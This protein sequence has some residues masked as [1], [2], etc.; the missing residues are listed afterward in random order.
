MTVVLF[1]LIL[2]ALIVGHEA[3]HFVI[4]KWVGMKVLEF[5][6]GFPPKLWGTK[7]GDTEYTVNLVPF[8]GF[9]RIFGEDESEKFEE[10]AFARHH[11]GAQAAVLVAGP[12]ANVLLAF[13]AFWVAF[14]VGVPA[15]IQEGADAATLRDARVVIAD[16][17]PSAPAAIAG[18]VA[19]DVVVSIAHDSVV[20]P[21]TRPEDIANVLRD[22][23]GPLSV[24]YTH[25]NERKTA[26]VT[27][28]TGIIPDFPDRYGIGIA[29]VLV[30]TKVLDP[31]A[32]LVSGF[33]A[34]WQ[35]LGSI[36]VGLVTL[37]GSALTFSASLSD[38]SGPVGIASLVGDAA[39]FGA[40][41]VLLLT[42]VIS[43]NLA[44][45]NLLPF[46]ALDGGRIAMLIV[47][48]LRGKE[49]KTSTTQLV[50]TAGFALLILIMLVVT[51]H[52]IAKLLA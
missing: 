41:Q 10:H 12:C 7:I 49:I 4:A 22:Y 34:T 30:G 52:D 29:S 17:L 28:V 47:E 11:K 37:V 31:L 15:A 16:T 32:A 51:Y 27:P 5:G 6:V 39:S 23:H 46:P 19:G 36:A 33:T 43:L 14:M 25:R 48:T 8:G 35:G 2:L 42:A 9:V 1:V 45:L 50:N 21:V 40:G 13:L 44:I 3:G 20:L 18:I 24:T 38:I 26:L